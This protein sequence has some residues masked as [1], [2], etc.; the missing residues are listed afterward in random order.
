[1]APNIR[2]PQS[3]SQNVTNSLIYSQATVDFVR[4]YMHL[5]GLSQKKDLKIGIKKIFKPKMIKINMSFSSSFM[6]TFPLLKQT[7][8]LF[9]LPVPLTSPELM[10]TVSSEWASWWR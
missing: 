5:P 2:Q 3:K 1:M 10:E 8:L 9:C 6:S 7:F 4:I